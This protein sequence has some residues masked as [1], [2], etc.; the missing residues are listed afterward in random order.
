MIIKLNKKKIQILLIISFV[1]CLSSINT[2]QNNLTN[3]FFL[4]EKSFF[5]YLNLVRFIAPTLIIVLL[6]FLFSFKK[7]FNKLLIYFF[8]YGVWQ[9]VIF[10]IE[11][12][13]PLDYI[14]NY[15]LILNSISI[16]LIFFLADHYN[17]RLEKKLLIILIIYISLIS[18]FFYAKFILEF[19]NNKNL[20]YFYTTETLKA[21]S[22]IFAQPIP[23]VTGLARIFV[24]I[25][26]F[27]FFLKFCV[28]N[29]FLKKIILITSFFLMIA[30][31]ATQT[32]GAF[33]GVSIFIIYY[34]FFFKHQIIKK[35]FNIFFIIL[36]PIVTFE[37]IIY[38]KSNYYQN[39]G[40]S[41]YY[42][43]LGESNL[44]QMTYLEIKNK[45]R[46]TNNY[47]SSGRIDI[48]KTS[49]KIIKEKKIIL[50]KGPQADRLLLSENQGKSILK[51]EARILDNNS[52]N[53]LI[54]SYL[55][56]GILSFTMFLFIYFFI[57]KKIFIHLFVKKVIEKKNF[58]TNFALITLIFLTIRTVFENG[59]AVF[60]I[61]YVFCIT[62]YFVLLKP[63]KEIKKN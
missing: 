55:C 15:Q 1:I 63:H 43:N 56:G 37:S 54:Y 26:Y 33:I 29:N 14:V 9:I 48:W 23:R 61:D 17:L 59:Y 18:L 45:N 27:L 31:Y 41:N 2:V 51:S 20:F 42:Q 8:I 6:S 50:G 4:K 10:T 16:L 52:S 39:L 7:K 47:T 49:I 21:E 5:N 12:S 62:C 3:F 35:V 60:G 34:L 28:T 22:E 30:I 57:I 19:F 13:N 40:E 24:I 32:R 38:L 25:F 11:N 53:A 44:E 36:I 46:I 58:I